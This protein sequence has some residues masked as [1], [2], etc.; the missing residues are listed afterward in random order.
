MSETRSKIQVAVV[1]HVGYGHTASRAKAVAA[2]AEAVAGVET[3]LFPVDGGDANWDELERARRP[4]LRCPDLHG[5]TFGSV[6][7]VPGCVL[8]SGDGR[9]LQVEGQGRRGIQQFGIPIRG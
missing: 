8:A 9:R 3:Q 4:H 6:Q 5:R 2:G 1:F 7:G